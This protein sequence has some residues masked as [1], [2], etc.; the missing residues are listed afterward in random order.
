MGV[1]YGLVRNS[2][3]NLVVFIYSLCNDSFCRLCF[4][5]LRKSQ[6]LLE[7]TSFCCLKSI[8]RGFFTFLFLD[9][10]LDTTLS[11]SNRFSKDHPHLT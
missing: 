7:Q 4:F 1:K 6:S 3:M 5:F 11:V 8:A 10:Y 2:F 9:M